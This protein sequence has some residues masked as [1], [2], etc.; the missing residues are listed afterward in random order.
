MLAAGLFIVGSAGSQEQSEPVPVVSDPVLATVDGTEIRTSALARRVV[1]LFQDSG[2]NIKVDGAEKLIEQ[3]RE[4]VL[5]QMISE[6]LLDNAATA[7]GTEVSDEEVGAMLADFRKRLPKGEAYDEYLRRYGA[8]DAM[9]KKDIQRNLR[10][11]KWVEGKTAD[12]PMPTAEE[13][14]A[15]YKER[16]EYAITLGRAKA[17][18]IL[19]ST[20]EVKDEEH[21][22]QRIREAKAIWDRLVGDN[23]E[24][25]EAVAREV[26]EDPKTASEG[27][28]LGEVK[29]GELED[30]LDRAIFTQP[31][32]VVGPAVPSRHGLHIIKVESRTKT[33]HHPLEEATPVIRRDLI[34]KRHNERVFEILDGLHDKA[35]I[36]VRDMETGELVDFKG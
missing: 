31:V 25:F 15:I 23:P 35:K 2:M 36:Q 3:M 33:K 29:E 5:A 9:V 19:L 12:L 10:V 34:G 4:Q 16:P 8:T 20:A 11:K 6:R 21:G 26:S 13:I 18:H 7:A 28:S 1:T 22:K 30:E 17:R 27:G 32:G 14:E 24:D